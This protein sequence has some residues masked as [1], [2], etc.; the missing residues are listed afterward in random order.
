ME[1]LLSVLCL[2]YICMERSWEKGRKEKRECKDII[3]RKEF[4]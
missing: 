4:L 3:F 2:E 1:M